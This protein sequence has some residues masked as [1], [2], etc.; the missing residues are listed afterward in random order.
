MGLE[1]AQKHVT[2]NATPEPKVIGALTKLLQACPTDFCRNEDLHD[3]AG[4]YARAFVR[5]EAAAYVG[6]SES[7]HYG[8]QDAINNCL[9]SDKCLAQDEIAVRRLP[10]FAP[11]SNFQGLGWV[12][13]LAIDAKLT[14]REKKRSTYFAVR[15]SS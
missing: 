9:D 8:L 7:I 6:Y 3:R 14:G 15:P 2:K 13:G 5:K 11:D 1:D 4:Y 10:S 12:D